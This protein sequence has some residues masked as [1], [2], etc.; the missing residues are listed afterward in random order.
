MFTVVIG[1]PRNYQI[2]VI[3]LIRGSNILKVYIVINTYYIIL[4]MSLNMTDRNTLHFNV[5]RV[6]AKINHIV[7]STFGGQI[8]D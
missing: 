3:K 8:I 6:P 1:Y 4:L 7:E 2:R 5:Y